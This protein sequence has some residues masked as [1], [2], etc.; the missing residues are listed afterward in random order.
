MTVSAV[1]AAFFAVAS[2]LHADQYKLLGGGVK[3]ENVGEYGLERL[4]Q[5]LT[6]E[7]AEFSNFKI[8]YPAARNA[9]TLY[10]VMYTTVIP[11][12]NNRSITVS[13]LLAVPQNVPGTRPIVSY[14]HG[15]VFSRTEV[16]STPEKSTETRLIIANFAAHGYVVI[17]AD[18]VGKGVSNEAD[19]FVVKDATAQACLD[20]LLAARVVCA[21]LHIP[22]GELFLSGWSQGAYNTC[23]LYTSPSPR[24]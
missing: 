1:V 16:P 21:D 13:G 15:T 12:E 18:Y 14:Q 7:V 2:G 4:N 6:S 22:T 10:R 9:V 3:Y 24:D 23:L 17:A 20:M 8:S 5:I 11:E 19:A